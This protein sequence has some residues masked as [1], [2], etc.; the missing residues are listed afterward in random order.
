MLP[1]VCCCCCCCCSAFGEK[2]IARVKSI[3]P[4]LGTY[5][6]RVSV[7]MKITFCFILIVCNIYLHWKAEVRIAVHFISWKLY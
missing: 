4:E 2:K 5:A 7:C 3:E 6:I 1:N